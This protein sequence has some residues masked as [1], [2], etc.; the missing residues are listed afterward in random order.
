MGLLTQEDPIGIAGGL[1]LYGFANGDPINFSDPFG[2]CPP[3]DENEED[4]ETESG[5]IGP[6]EGDQ[7]VVGGFGNPGQFGAP[8]EVREAMGGWGSPGQFGSAP[9]DSGEQLAEALDN[10]VVTAV[11]I[12]ALTRGIAGLVGK[13]VALANANRYLRIGPG[14]WGSERWFRASGQV[15]DFLKRKKDAHINIKYLGPWGR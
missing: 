15:I 5:E 10:P 1:N 8:A 7:Q 2:L 12:A 9:V 11:A 6:A 14:R 13:G 4:C 3:E